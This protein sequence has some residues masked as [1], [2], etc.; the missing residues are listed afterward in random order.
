MNFKITSHTHHK[1]RHHVSVGIFFAY[2]DDVLLKVKIHVHIYKQININMWWV[3]LIIIFKLKI[4][5]ERT[6]H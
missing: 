1:V 3:I 5:L 4:L 6:E 2:V